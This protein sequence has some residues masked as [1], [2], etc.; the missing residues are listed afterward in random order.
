MSADT[1]VNQ[2]IFQNDHFDFLG[3]QQYQIEILLELHLVMIWNL[4]RIKFTCKV[5][6]TLQPFSYFLCFLQIFRDSGDLGCDTKG[7]TRGV[8]VNVLDC[9]IVDSEFELQSCYSDLF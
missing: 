9:D 4:L 7:G 3:R 2:V 6:I 8:V 5:L 1:Q